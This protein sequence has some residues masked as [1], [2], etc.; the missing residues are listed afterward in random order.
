MTDNVIDPLSFDAE[1]VNWQISMMVPGRYGKV[2]ATGRIYNQNNPR[3]NNGDY[4]N[5][6]PIQSFDFDNMIITTLN[7]RYKLVQ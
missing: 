5:T 7:S 1:L 2:C 6:S 4:I 3:F